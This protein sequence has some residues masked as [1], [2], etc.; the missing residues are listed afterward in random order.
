MSTQLFTIGYEGLDLQAFVRCLEDN[1][2]QCIIDMPRVVI[3][4]K[5]GGGHICHCEHGAASGRNQKCLLKK[6]DVAP[7]QRSE[8]ISH[9]ED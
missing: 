1:G 7:L 6:Q 8:A 9:P 2:I 5:A 3:P 4:A